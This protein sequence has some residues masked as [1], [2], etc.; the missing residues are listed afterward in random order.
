MKSTIN[1]IFNYSALALSLLVT[2]NTACTSE[3]DLD[4]DVIVNETVKSDSEIS[5]NDNEDGTDPSLIFCG[6]QYIYIIDAQK[7]YS[8]RYQNAV[9]ESWNAASIADTIG[10]SENLCKYLTD[11]KPV[12]DGK[13]LLVTSYNGWSIL[14]NLETMDV[15]FYT[16]NSFGAHSADLLPNDRVAVACANPGNQIQVYDLDTPNKIISSVQISG[17]QGV[18]WDADLNLLFAINQESL[19]SYRLVD[20]SSNH[21]SLELVASVPTPKKGMKDLTVVSSNTLCVAGA[22]SYIYNISDNTFTEM[23]QFSSSKVLN[24]MNYNGKTGEVW[25]TDATV[26]AG[27]AIWSTRSLSYSN[28]VNGSGGASEISISDLDVYAVRVLHW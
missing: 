1:N 15:P 24:S 9:I 10:L 19:N 6:D 5:F 21:P 13:D 8:S 26:P 3:K 4:T 25:Y 27:R 17:A 20:W 22:G 2:F 12:N 28:N 11:C 16:I 7:A 14:L 18:A 23:T